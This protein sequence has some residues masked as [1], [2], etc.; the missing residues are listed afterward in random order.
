M[1]NTSSTCNDNNIYVRHTKTHISKTMYYH[2]HSHINNLLIQHQQRSLRNDTSS[3]TILNIIRKVLSKKETLRGYSADILN[4]LHDEDITFKAFLDVCIYCIQNKLRS[5]TDIHIIK[6]YL[7]TLSPFVNVIKQY[8]RGIFLDEYMQTISMYIEYKHIQQRQIICKYGDNGDKAYLILN[9]DVDILTKQSKHVQLTKH[10]YLRYLGKLLKYGEYGLLSATLYANYHTIPIEVVKVNEY[11]QLNLQRDDYLW[12]YEGSC[13]AASSID[14]VVYSVDELLTLVGDETYVN[15]NCVDSY[16]ERIQ[17]C[18]IGSNNGDTVLNVVVYTYIHLTSKTKGD[19]IGEHALT[20]KSVRCATLISKTPCHLGL[21]SKNVYDLTLK[22]CIDTIKRNNITFLH[23]FTLFSKINSHTLNIKYY[24]NFVNETLQRN[25]L[26]LSQSTPLDHIYLIK[27][28]LFH[29]TYTGSLY[30]LLNLKYEY[31][32]K[33]M[34]YMLKH[35]TNPQKNAIDVDYYM[36]KINVSKNKEMSYYK[37]LLHD[38][39]SFK[40]ELHKRNVFLIM[41]AVSPDIV[42]LFEYVNDTTRES[43][44]TVKCV[45]AKGEVL[46]LYNSSFDEIKFDNKLINGVEV[47]LTK[48]K[49]SQV[50]DRIELLLQTKV[51]VFV[52][53]TKSVKEDITRCNANEKEIQM[54]R[55][56]KVNAFAF[57]PGICSFMLCKNFNCKNHKAKPITLNLMYKQNTNDLRNSTNTNNNN[58]NVC[59]SNSVSSTTTTNALYSFT[60]AKL[61]KTNSHA[62]SN[63]TVSCSNNTSNQSRNNTSLFIKHKRCKART[64]ITPFYSSYNDNKGVSTS[65]R[66]IS[67]KESCCDES[68]QVPL[69]FIQPLLNKK[70]IYNKMDIYYYNKTINSNHH[71]AVNELKKLG[72][73]NCST[74]GMNS[75]RHRRNSKMR[76]NSVDKYNNT[77]RRSFTLLNKDC[78]YKPSLLLK[79]K[80]KYNFNNYKQTI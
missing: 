55:K 69:M 22:K 66:V 12:R 57:N 63:T 43:Y 9:G 70:H 28:G 7:Y 30:D 51:D 14:D 61:T 37:T 26:I 50:V 31:K 41:Q 72:V 27:D 42:G 53:G 52:K 21:I 80:Y 23:S 71:K 44:F 18:M 56:V 75:N 65:S 76:L 3:T 40:G 39:P 25:A 73:I 79:C 4:A 11:K 49:L 45:S 35:S 38:Y 8:E 46:I 68:M 6:G 47:D 78:K 19:I 20:N 36:N 16:I 60:K 64:T 74:T 77:K 13:I 17:P 48:Q 33:Q 34:K 1:S 58:D 54:Q 5:I 32:L 10:S 24:T 59:N 15:V 62:N 2:H 29:I 67:K